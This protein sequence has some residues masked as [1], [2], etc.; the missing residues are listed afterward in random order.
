MSKTGLLTSE[1]SQ[2]DL[3]WRQT[4]NFAELFEYPPETGFCCLQT[5][6][7]RVIVQ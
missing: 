7:L 1:A 2:S 5:L 6:H 4:K 3:Q